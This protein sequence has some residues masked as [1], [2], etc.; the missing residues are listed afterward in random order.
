[1][2]VSP[3]V[4][5]TMNNN[6]KIQNDWYLK[7]DGKIDL[8][9]KS[10]LVQT[11]NS[12]LDVTS[13]GF[14]ERDQQGQ[15]NLFNYNY[16]CSPVGGISTTSNNNSYTVDSVMK[17]GTDPEN[18]K[19]FTW[20]TGY[21]GAPTTPITLSTYWLFKFQN[22]TPVYANWAKVTQTE[23]LFASQGFTMKG[24]GAATATQNYTFI[25][26]P[27]S[28]VISSPIAA[29]NS[30]VS[31]NPYPSALDATAF[32]N[33]NISS[34]N[35]SLYFWEHYPTNSSHVLV[36]YQGGYAT[37]NLVGGTTPV[38]PAGISGLGSSSRIPGR[39][40]P[41]GQ[42][43]FINGNATGG[44]INFNNSQR[45]FIK[46]DDAVNS[47][48]LFRNNN[49]KVIKKEFDNR[50]DAIPQDNKFTKIRFSYISPDNNRR[51]LLLG[52]MNEN[53]TS[54]IDPGYDA[55]QLDTQDSDMY[56][57][58]NNTK[59][60]I[61]GDTYFDSASSFPLGVKTAIGGKA[62]FVLNQTENFDANS[63]IYIYDNVT[64]LYH[65]IKE[66]DLEIN[67]TA[68]TLADR[69]SLRFNNP[70]TLS[71]NNFDVKNTCK[72]YV[73]NNILTTDSPQHLSWCSIYDM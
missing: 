43:F 54:D 18:I 10:Q 44:T 7:L 46:E 47:N 73:K 34:T 5:I 40:I 23:N 67:L 12:D 39:Y 21:N 32:I 9:G 62:K 36:K 61:Q 38:S 59:L 50:Q 25:G 3:S 17:D 6:T 27:N 30:N 14:I 11:I 37:R 45:L 64:K 57:L 48:V 60:V 51:E 42:G 20:T 68:G 1:M 72:V 69:F 13:S 29:N 24:S 49:S 22:V 66:K 4:T 28:G 55:V 31:G 52:F 33:A 15:S 8:Q 56:F 26:K 70:V 63:S 53:A 58:N 16:W 19:N 41:V 71:V 35:G 65:D 2:F